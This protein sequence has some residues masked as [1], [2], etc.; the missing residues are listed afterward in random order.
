MRTLTEEEYKLIKSDTDLLFDFCIKNNLI[1]DVFKERISGISYWA[2]NFK[3]HHNAKGQAFHLL[4]RIELKD[5]IFSDEY[6]RRRIV[7]HEIGHLLYDYDMNESCDITIKRKLLEIYN[8]NNLKEGNPIL[9]STG[10]KMLQEYLM[11]KFSILVINDI[12]NKPIELTKNA[13]GKFSGNI[14]YDT[15]FNNSYGILESFCDELIFKYYSD[16][17]DVFRDCLG[18]NFYYNLL[19][20][21]DEKDIFKFLEYM[22][23][24][25]NLSLPYTNE[26]II[27]KEDDVKQIIESLR[28]LAKRISVKDKIK[29]QDSISYYIK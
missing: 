1:N 13:T 29:E 7:F 10:F 12:L 25:Y 24:L 26:G 20:N 15:T 14:K 5:D 4:K 2:D 16:I 6:M 3:N 11:D 17:L 9:A 23:K 18:P 19:D 27:P 21:Y 8:R 28:A 22:G